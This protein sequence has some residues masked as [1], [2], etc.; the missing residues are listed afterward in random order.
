[1][2][3][4]ISTSDFA[5]TPI[6]SIAFVPFLYA[7]LV[8]SL[9][10]EIRIIMRFRSQASNDVIRYGLW[11]VFRHCGL[12]LARLRAL[13]TSRPLRLLGIRSRVDVDALFVEDFLDDEAINN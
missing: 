1:M 2:L 10:D 9:Y 4:T 13:R 7:M 11:R 8:V 5:L 12:D 6:L 3:G